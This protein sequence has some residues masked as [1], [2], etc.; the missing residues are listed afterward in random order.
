M[1]EVYIVQMDVKNERGE[2]S[3]NVHHFVTVSE[4]SSFI[5]IHIYYFKRLLTVPKVNAFMFI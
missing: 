5:Y 3:H 4:R 1:P 2:C